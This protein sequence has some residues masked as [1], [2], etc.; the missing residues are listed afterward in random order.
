MRSAVIEQPFRTFGHLSIQHS[1][2]RASS[3]LRRGVAQ[4]QQHETDTRIDQCFSDG[5]VDGVI[6]GVNTT[7]PIVA[8]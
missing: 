6:T 1:H 3:A 7:P 8:F 4:H 2:D 5:G